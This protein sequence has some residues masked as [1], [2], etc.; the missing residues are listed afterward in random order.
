MQQ[1][2]ALELL[3]EMDRKREQMNQLNLELKKSLT[4]GEIFGEQIWDN[5]RVSTQVYGN[6]RDQ[7]HFV[8]FCDQKKTEVDLLD[9]PVI[10]WPEEV[11]HDIL[12]CYGLIS[13]YLQQLKKKLRE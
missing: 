7:M 12:S 9:V 2:K 1:T 8:L 5:Q 6:P 13:P 4:L 3:E 10:L 11:K